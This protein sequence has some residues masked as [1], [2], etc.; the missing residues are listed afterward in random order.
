M[1]RHPFALGLLFVVCV[2]GRPARGS[3]I[4][5]NV[6]ARPVTAERIAALPAAEQ[7]AWREYLARTRAQR[8]T[9]QLALQQ[10]LARRGLQES[11]RPPAD[12]NARSL[13]LTRPPEWYAGAEAR[14]LADIVLSF[15]TPAGGWSKNLDLSRHPRAA[16]ESFAPDNR[17][18]FVGTNDNDALG[19]VQWSY[20]GTIDNGAT[21]SELRFLAKVI[22]AAGSNAPAAYREAF[23]RGCGYLFAAQYPN[24][25]WP[26]VWPLQGGYHDA[27][28]YNDNAMLNVMQF[29]QEV[30]AGREDYPFTSAELRQQAAASVRRA[31]TCLLA[32][33]VRENGRRTV[34]CQQH[35]ALTLL[36][37]AARNFEMSSL[38]SAESAALA[39]LL[40]EL[41]RPD[42]EVE[43]AVR[44]A[45][46][47]FERTQIRDQAFRTVP[48]QGRLLV[49]TPG[50]GPV[51]ARFYQI[52]TDRPIFGDRDKTIHDD[53]A[54]L[55]RER[56]DGYAWFTGNPRE[57]LRDF[58][59]W[60]AAK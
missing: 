9:D 6:A 45:A 27:I 54:D 20:V 25:G 50:S 18:R 19:G 55:S 38:C 53:V 29:L 56:R 44:G 21:T 31:V 43:A 52:G 37:T 13:P 1:T 39:R 36:P 5:T 32:T 24:G 30:A 22:A 42:A 2:G 16:G 59:K 26:Q 60:T 49:P 33:Q 11:T 10:E 51:W 48:G 12:K 8:R 57:L 40:M 46:A 28:T 3:A 15:Q 47:W 7:P 23:T 58:A 35:D 17:S 34:W 41:P 4:G 14:R